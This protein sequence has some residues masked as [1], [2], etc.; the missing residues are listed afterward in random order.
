MKQRLLHA[1]LIA[2][3]VMLA[4]VPVV[5]AQEGD[6]LLYGGNQDIENIDP[7]TGE[8]RDRDIAL[9]FVAEAGAKPADPLR[10]RLASERKLAERNLSEIIKPLIRGNFSAK[11]RSALHLNLK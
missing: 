10:A 3:L 7:A 4:I 2:V 1:L 8:L 11:W 9:D 6:I 5:G